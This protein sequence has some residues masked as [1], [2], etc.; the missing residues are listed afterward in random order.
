M[1]QH[2][3]IHDEGDCRSIQAAEAATDI[4]ADDADEYATRLAVYQVMQT[5]VCAVAIVGLL[6]AFV[7][8]V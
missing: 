2:A 8:L 5:L 1:R 7:A 6:A 4:G 3:P